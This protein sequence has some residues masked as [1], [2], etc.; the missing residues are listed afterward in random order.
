MTYEEFQLIPYDGLGH[1]LIKKVHVITPAPSSKH[2][3]V[4]SIISQSLGNFVA[5]KQIGKVLTAPYDIKFSDDSGH[6]PDI[7]LIT[8]E[9][10]KNIKENYYEG[11]PLV[12]IEIISPGSKKNDYVWK[13]NM[14]EE[15]MVPEYWIFNIEEKL[16]DLFYL[17]RKKYNYNTFRESDYLKSTLQELK[18]YKLHLK[19]IFES[20]KELS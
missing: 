2:R 15:F 1:H 12:L 14:V 11:I 4:S 3:W 7:I 20:L 10:Y 16:V 13:R 6:Q 5:S 17:S 18:D 8:K 19:T 9:N